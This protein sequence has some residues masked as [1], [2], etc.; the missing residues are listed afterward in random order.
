MPSAAMK[1]PVILCV[2]DE[3]GILHSIKRCL[4][5]EHYEV[6]TASGGIQALEILESRLG[7]V[8]LMI[9]D[10]RMPQMTGDEFLSHVRA[11][12]GRIRAIMISGY[13]DLARISGELNDG[14]ICRIL[15]KPWDNKELLEAI[16]TA[17]P[18]GEPA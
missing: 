5:F 8:D 7:A 17:L 16:R 4:A 13:L 1:F 2:D 3:L 9:V 6:L 18:A 15:E 11:R 14:G 12:Y 10:Y